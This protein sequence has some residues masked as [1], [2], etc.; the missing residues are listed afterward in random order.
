MDGY[1]GY[2]VRQGSYALVNAFAAWDVLPKLTLRA[3]VNNIGDKK[4]ITSLYNIG[5]YGAPTNYM[6]SLDWRF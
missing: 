2:T 3:N 6:V 5:Y 4:Y 1:T